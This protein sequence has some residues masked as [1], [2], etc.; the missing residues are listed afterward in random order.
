MNKTQAVNSQ[1]A[2]VSTGSTPTAL[3]FVCSRVLLC[4]LVGA[5]SSFHC[6]LCH[7]NCH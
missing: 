6:S 2:S 3:S 7:C 5:Q 1:H 4:G